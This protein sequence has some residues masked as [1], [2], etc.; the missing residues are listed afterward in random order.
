M[1]II[2]T[3]DIH[4]MLPP[5]QDI[6]EGDVLVLAGDICPD[7]IREYYTGVSHNSV[8]Y[9]RGE[10]RQADWLDTEF[11]AWLEA[12]P[13]DA[14]NIVGIAGNHDFVFEKRSLVPDLPWT[15][16]QDSGCTI[17]GVSFWGT[18]W[19]PRLSFWAFYGTTDTLVNAF[20]LIPSG[21]DVLVSHGPPYGYLDIAPD[22]YG[23]AMKG[24]H[25]GSTEL[26]DALKV[27]EP[28]VVI[29]GHIHGEK[30]K[31]RT[32]KFNELTTIRNVS[33]CNEAYE[34]IQPIEVI[35]V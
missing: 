20:S 22:K 25:V 34:P 27:T 21:I 18:P 26:A 29:C 28:Q 8:K 30:G 15:Y 5:P 1:R 35:D 4:G 31:M 23:Q 16:L 33:L 10:T 6:P 13:F 3:S 32:E 2:A 24:R 19:V 12:V 14:E 11:R 17:D 9:D 7:R